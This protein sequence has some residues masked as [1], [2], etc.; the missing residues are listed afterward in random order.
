MHTSI[1]KQLGLND[2]EI[3]VYV[4]LLELGTTS[5]GELLKT[6]E[7]H[8]GLLYD[9][10]DRLIEKG[11]ASY[12][13]KNNRKYFEAT[14]P[15]SL[16]DFAE[17]KVMEATQIKHEVLDIIPALN[18]MR[19]ISSEDQDVTLFKGTKGIKSVLDR[20][21]EAKEVHTMGGISQPEGMHHNLQIILQNYHAKR[22]AKKIKTNFI[23][24]KSGI[25]RAKEVASMKYIKV[26]IL[27]NELESS[28]GISLFKDQVVIVLWSSNP[29]AIL[30]KSKSIHDSYLNH[31]N[32]LWKQGKELK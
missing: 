29:I 13:I 15:E 22:L 4:A 18:A 8:R 10:L 1:L 30:I 16:L 23:F 17:Q 20:M 14:P 21:L 6:I 7:L 28:T 24:S 25:V 12:V 2:T 19:K 27:E 26:R 11:I 5:A 32:Y 31:F 9:T 3:K